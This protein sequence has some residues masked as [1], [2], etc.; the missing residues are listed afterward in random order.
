MDISIIGVLGNL[1]IKFLENS[2]YYARNILCT[3]NSKIMNSKHTD[4]VSIK[5][6]Q[7]LTLFLESCFSC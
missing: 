3:R 4:L 7:I 1:R 2:E 6:M 5:L